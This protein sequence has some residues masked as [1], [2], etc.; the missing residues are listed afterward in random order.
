[1]Q[2]QL[3]VGCAIRYLECSWLETPAVIG[4]LRPI[5]L[6]P[7]NALTGLSEEQLKAVIGH[8]LAHIRRRDWAINLFQR[9]AKSMLWRDGAYP[10]HRKPGDPFGPAARQTS[11]T[12]GL[13][14]AKGTFTSYPR[15][16]WQGTLSEPPRRYP[17]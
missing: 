15:S 11:A 8:E 14:T 7:V 5:M 3:G 6:L 9:R 1:M 16:R 12:L 13:S 17:G 2:R 4:W 10:W